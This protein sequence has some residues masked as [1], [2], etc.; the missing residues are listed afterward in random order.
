MP[1]SISIYLTDLGRFIH[2]LKLN[3]PKTDLIFFLRSLSFP[4]FSVARTSAENLTG[5]FHSSL[6][7]L[8]ITV[9]AKA[10]WFL[11]HTYQ[12]YDPSSRSLQL[13]SM[14]VSLLCSISFIT[15]SCSLGCYPTLSIPFRILQLKSSFSALWNQVSPLH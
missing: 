7:F 12:A 13:E 5:V 1:K 6:S 15:S 11:Q 2:Q 3:I 4:L 9:F 14:Q 8:K 10:F